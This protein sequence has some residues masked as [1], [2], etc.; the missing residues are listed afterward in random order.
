MDGQF[1]APSFIPKKPLATRSGSAISFGGLFLFVSILVFILSVGGYIGLYFYAQSIEK[2][3]ETSRVAVQKKLADKAVTE[4]DVNNLFNFNNKIKIAK[5]LL[6]IGAPGDTTQHTTL[7]PFF[8][9]LREA[10]L[11]TVRFKDFKFTNMDNS[12]IE[13]R[14]SGEAKGYPSVAF[15]AEAFDV[16]G[17]LSNV[18]FTDLNQGPNNLVIFN[19]SATVDPSM[20]SYAKLVK[21]MMQQ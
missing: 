3:I 9:F 14:M 21:S 1:G 17:K 20:I 6:Y 7:T 19:M 13:I 5:D 16:V 10:T 4:K 2:T 18:V 11:K 12:R 8:N 15:Q